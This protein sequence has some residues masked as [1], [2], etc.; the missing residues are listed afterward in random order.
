MYIEM[1][2]VPIIKTPI[3]KIEM[4]RPKKKLCFLMP[5]HYLVGYGG[6]E[7]QVG[8]V[9]EN[10]IKRNEYD[11]HFL[12]RRV[13][14]DSMVVNQRVWKIGSENGFG[15]YGTYFDAIRLYSIL[16][17]IQPDIIYQ[18][19]GCAYTGIAA[20]YAKKHGSALLWHIA[21][22]VDLAPEI[23]TGLKNRIINCPERVILNYGIKNATF[24]AAQTQYQSMLLERNFGR[25]S[26]KI[27]P[28]GHPFPEHIEPKAPPIKVLWIANLKPLKQPEIFLELARR[29]SEARQVKFLM[30][31]RLV[32]PPEWAKRLKQQIDNGQNLQYLG[33]I[34]QNVVNSLLTQGHILVNTS[35][36]EGFSN[37][38]VQA[39]M[40]RVPVVSLKVNPDDLL[41]SRSIGFH[42]RSFTQLCLDVERLILDNQLREKMGDNARHYALENHSV[43]KMVNSFMYFVQLAKK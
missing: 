31:G 23:D 14:P 33:H 7:Y 32:G 26:D 24:I 13:P 19:V 11:I 29:F 12:C 38:F 30:M 18:N 22:D 16:R 34:P 37:T 41:T 20:Y 28:V 36:Y 10:I 43:E 3:K 21:S 6:A 17:K 1:L 5:V 25:R 27:I 8:L 9:M 42:S 2:A 40:R 39:W 35:R 4:T 15:R